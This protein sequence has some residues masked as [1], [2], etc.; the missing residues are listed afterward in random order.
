MMAIVGSH[1]P[2]NAS[3]R[4]PDLGFLALHR[5]MLSDQI[6]TNAYRD[7]ILGNKHLFQNKSVL[8][9]GCG[10][11]ILSLFCAEAG[12]KRVYAVDQSSIINCARENV[13]RAGKQ[14][15]IEYDIDPPRLPCSSN[16]TPAFM[17]DI[18]RRFF[19][20]KLEDVALPIPPNSID[21]L[22]SEW[23]G[24]CLLFEGMA[25]PLIYARD[26]HL[27]RETGLMVP[28]HAS[29]YLA[30]FNHPEYTKDRI[31]YWDDVYGYDMS[32]MRS[33]LYIEIDTDTTLPQEHLLAP[34]QPFLELDMH[35]VK[36][37]DLVFSGCTFE[38]I[39]P[40]P[41]LKADSEDS[42]QSE[43]TKSGPTLDGFAIWFDISFHPARASRP[44]APPSSTKSQQASPPPPPEFTTVTFT[45][46]PHGP[47][48]HWHQGLCL[49]DRNDMPPR[50]TTEHQNTRTDSQTAAA[51]TKKTTI[52][53][54][55]IGYS[56]EDASA[57]TGEKVTEGGLDVTIA[58]KIVDVDVDVDELE[59]E[60]EAGR[61]ES[62]VREKGKQT[63]SLH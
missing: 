14:D 13:F 12:A 55:M 49:I 16:V 58:W 31:H 47:E 44:S 63:W 36:S 18:A 15:V 52:V 59:P 38:F 10:T 39:L 27:S 20:G 48:T 11:G 30:P 4:S 33:M 34:A 35:T 17:T 26:R 23:M 50:S 3:T 19:H 60:S 7:F 51:E 53:R 28:S 5:S 21:V 37:D 25:L 62:V 43:E 56:S 8:D 29:L 45:T 40:H 24:Y 46:G 41:D 2:S 32:S 6:R 9:V 22:I 42:E 61:R 1:P 54:G 57:G